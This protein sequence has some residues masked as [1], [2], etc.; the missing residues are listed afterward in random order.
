MSHLQPDVSLY[1]QGTARCENVGWTIRRSRSS[2]PKITDKVGWGRFFLPV[3]E[4]SGR[5]INLCFEMLCFAAFSNITRT[6]ELL[7]QSLERAVAKM[8]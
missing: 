7:H 1:S 5:K 2:G 8:E 3:L 4:G 6:S